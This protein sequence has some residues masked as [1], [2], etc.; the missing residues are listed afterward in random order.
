MGVIVANH[1]KPT[2]KKNP[3]FSGGGIKEKSLS[4]TVKKKES[5]N[6]T[7]EK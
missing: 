7:E 1:K 6:K 4:I 3:K 5:N 2:L